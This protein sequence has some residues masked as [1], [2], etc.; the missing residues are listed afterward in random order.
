MI[1]TLFLTIV[2]AFIYALTAIFRLAPDVALSPSI[3][4]SVATP[5]SLALSI[6]DFFPVTETLIIFTGVFVVYEVAYFGYKIIM[7]IIRK[8]PGIS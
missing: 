3:A 5:V 1:V 2:Y 8:I 6:N 7:W 4:Q